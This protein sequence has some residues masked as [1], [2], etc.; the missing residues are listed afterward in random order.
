M[1]TAR[2]PSLSLLA[3]LQLTLT[4]ALFVQGKVH[5]LGVH[6]CNSTALAEV[7]HPMLR[8]SLHT[9]PYP[10]TAHFL[11]LVAEYAGCKSYR[12]FL[13]KCYPEHDSRHVEIPAL[14]FSGRQGV[15]DASVPML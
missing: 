14:T 6:L 8:D 15:I 12:H 10:S 11:Q 1:S 13:E 4:A 7:F 9:G 2:N 3:S 5:Q